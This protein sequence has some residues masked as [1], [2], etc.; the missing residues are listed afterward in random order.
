MA[1]IVRR[2]INGPGYKVMKR[3]VIEANYSKGNSMA[4]VPRKSEKVRKH[5][6]VDGNG[7]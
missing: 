7:T 4:L 6:C 5:K 3:N 2:R 1:L